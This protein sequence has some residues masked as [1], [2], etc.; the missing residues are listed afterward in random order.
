M[1]T[2]MLLEWKWE[3]VSTFIEEKQSKLV[4]LPSRE[5]VQFTFGQSTLVTD[6][7][8]NAEKVICTTKF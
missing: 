4:T 1:M 6:E 7:S 8:Q 2:P 5:G 3:L